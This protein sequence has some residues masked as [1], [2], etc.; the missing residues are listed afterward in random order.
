[1][2]PLHDRVLQDRHIHV[3]EAKP[4]TE[5]EILRVVVQ[6]GDGVEQLAGIG[7]G[8]ARTAVDRP[9]RNPARDCIGVQKVK[10]GRYQGIHGANRRAVQRDETDR[11]LPQRAIGADELHKVASGELVGAVG[12]LRELDVAR[13]RRRAANQAG[14]VQT[15]AAVVADVE[16]PDVGKRAE[17]NQAGLAAIATA[18]AVEAAADHHI[19]T[20]LQ[21]QCE[22]RAVGTCAQR[23]RDA[24]K[25]VVGRVHEAGVQ[26]TVRQQPGDP[27]P[28][29]AV[30]GLEQATN[31]NRPVRLLRDGI[32]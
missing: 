11:R 22:A 29:R 18:H 14:H 4:W 20:G 15:R 31:Q 16:R 23:L 21:C 24:G 9:S 1:M 19:P 28:P 26:H 10:P 32:H 2:I 30:E 7:S 3:C 25:V 27:H 6:P 12:R 5:P 17:R 13:S 8:V